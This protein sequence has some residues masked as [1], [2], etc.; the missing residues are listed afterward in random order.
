MNIDMTY[1]KMSVWGLLFGLFTHAHTHYTT[2]K[3]YFS[4]QRPSGL[5]VFDLSLEVGALQL[6]ERLA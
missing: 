5:K 1:I 3:I 6:C 2:H 4:P